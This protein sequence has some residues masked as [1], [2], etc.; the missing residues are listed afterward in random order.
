MR[1]VLVLNLVGLTPRLLQSGAMPAVA[2][3]ARRHGLRALRPSLPAVTCTV[4]ASMLLGD[5]A[6]P[7]Y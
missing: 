2:A 3:H 7:T 4:Q 5:P 6:K 1:R